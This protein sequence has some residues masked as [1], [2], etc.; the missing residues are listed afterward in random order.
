M[1]SSTYRKTRFVCIS[2]THNA[3][4]GTGAFKLPKGDVLVHA[5]DLTKQGTYAELR[6]TL[7]WI[8][9]ADFEVKIVVAGNHD[10]TLDKEF[11]AAHGSYFHNQKPQNP[12]DCSMMFENSSVIYLNHEARN[13]ILEKEDGP[14]T[15]F[16]V[17]GSPYSPAK[18]LWAFGYRD[19]AAASLWEQIPLDTDIVVTHTP[20]KYHCDVTGARASAGCDILR[21]NLWRVRPRLAICGHIHE[22]RGAERVFWDLT[23]S[24]VR[25]REAFTNYWVDPA[26]ESKKQCLI[27]L[28]SRGLVPLNNADTTRSNATNHI[29]NETKSPHMVSPQWKQKVSFAEQSISDG[30]I[31]SSP[32]S[33]IVS[34]QHPVAGRG[35]GGIPPSPRCD[36][37]ALA[38]NLDR[39]ETCVVNAAIMASS[40]PYKA[41]GR[42]KYHKPFVI[43]VD[44]PT[45]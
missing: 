18:G 29:D 6:K 11:Y 7:D 1:A 40:W 10:I 8:E 21:Q 32:A 24:N 39:R 37:Q 45:Q 25:Y 44:L 28:T 23:C 38:G 42:R 17:F 13:I 22:G 31:E 12:E 14:R 3:S 19:E 34:V 33:P 27:D 43:D 16:K 2:D 20:P 41:A 36:L 15:T 9:K 30:T 4:P 35:Q 5:G 26:L